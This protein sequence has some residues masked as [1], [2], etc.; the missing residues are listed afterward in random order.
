MAVDEPGHDGPPSGIHDPL[1]A[2]SVGGGLRIV[3]A[4]DPRDDAVLDPDRGVADEAGRVSGVV[5]GADDVRRQ[6][7]DPRDQQGCYGVSSI[8]IVRPRSR[9]TSRA[10]G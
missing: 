9:A 1:D 7:A 3:R 4:P 5:A 6:L 10:R 2:A 8:G